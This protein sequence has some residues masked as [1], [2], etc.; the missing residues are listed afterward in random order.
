MSEQWK[1]PPKASRHKPN[2]KHKPGEDNN[3]END[4]VQVHKGFGLL[5]GT[6]EM[7]Q[8]ESDHHTDAEKTGSRMQHIES[9]K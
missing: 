8:L 5:A 4:R 6:G 2:I 3:L 1:Q 7:V 9:T